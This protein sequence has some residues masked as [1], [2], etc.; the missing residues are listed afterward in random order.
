[1]AELLEAAAAWIALSVET[2]AAI[3]IGLG[4]VEALVSTFRPQP[5]ATLGRKRLVWAHFARWL[6]LALE[7]E[8]AADIIRTAISPT[9][10]DI[11]QLGAI[12]VIRTFLNYF[13][14]SDLRELREADRTE[15]AERFAESS[16]QAGA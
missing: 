7:F 13:L 4:A 3:L 8:L 15:T 9:W 14:A 16:S 5:R 6:A 10:D 1:V 11:G 12:A 2:A